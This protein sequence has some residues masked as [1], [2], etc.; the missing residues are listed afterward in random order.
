MSATPRLLKVFDDLVVKIV[1]FADVPADQDSAFV[2][3]KNAKGEPADDVFAFEA[4]VVKIVEGARE[5]RFVLGV[6]ATPNKVDGHG[7]VIPPEVIR[8]AAHDYLAHYRQTDDNH[9]LRPLLGGA[10]PGVPVESYITPH[11]ATFETPRG[12]KTVPAG[13]WML[14]VK[15]TDD[16]LWAKVKSGK[17][18]G[19]SIWGRALKRRVSSDDPSLANVRKTSDEAAAIAEPDQEDEVNSDMK[20]EEVETVVKTLLAAALAPIASGLEDV[21]KTL[22][23]ANG[24]L[25]SVEKTLSATDVAKL[26]ATVETVQKTVSAIESDLG[27]PVRKALRQQHEAAPTKLGSVLANI[28][29]KQKA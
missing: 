23:S 25:E 26:A 4:P 21:R 20:P 2:V 11:D 28:T 24:R 3:V 27:E 29:P 9:D 8:K 1:A 16:A 10:S 14:G 6:V 7:E 19:F 18:T 5:E 17:T 13:S 15:V 22:T 12:P